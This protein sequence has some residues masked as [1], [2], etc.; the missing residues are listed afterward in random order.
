MTLLIR[1]GKFGP[2]RPSRCT[3]EDQHVERY[4]RGGLVAIDFSRCTLNASGSRLVVRPSV[5]APQ[6]S[7][8]E[9]DSYPEHQLIIIQPR[10]AR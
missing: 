10:Q 9:G 1:D 7:T 6:F 5:N 8:R 3:H 2:R 4:T